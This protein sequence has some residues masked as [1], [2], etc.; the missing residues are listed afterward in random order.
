[1]ITC[2]A[3]GGAPVTLVLRQCGAVY[4]ELTM[5]PLVHIGGPVAPQAL[6]RYVWDP[7][8][9]VNR[10]GSWGYC[11][12]NWRLGPA[13]D[14]SELWLVA[15]ALM[16]IAR[17]LVLWPTSPECPH[18]A[19]SSGRPP[20]RTPFSLRTRARSR[21]WAASTPGSRALALR[22]RR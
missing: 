7:I 9:C 2:G 11:A 12:Y 6:A 8:R 14:G 1:M 13:F 15:L 16:F 10:G 21:R 3:S 22:H 20:Q 18:A 5:T 17:H 4:S 19:M